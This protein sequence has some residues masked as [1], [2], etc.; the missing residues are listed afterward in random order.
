MKLK[1]PEADYAV[2]RL[3]THEAGEGMLQPS[4][5][6]DGVFSWRFSAPQDDCVM[7]YFFVVGAHDNV[8]CY[9]NNDK[10][11]GGE[12]RVYYQ[13]ETPESFQI[14]VYHPF[15]LPEWYKEGIIY[16]IFPDRF[17]RSKAAEKMIADAK[18]AAEKAAE[19]AKENG[20]AA[21]EPV[22]TSDFAPGAFYDPQSGHV[23]ENWDT[24]PYY[25]KNEDG[26]I[27]NWNFWGG[28]LAGIEEK[29]EYIRSLGAS[30]IYLNPIFEA[31]SNH[32]YDTSDYFK[33]DPLLGTEEDFRRLCSKA[34]KLGI[35]IMLDGVFN[36]TGVNSKYYREHPEWFQK[37]ENGE[38][39]CWWGVKDLPQV[40]ELNPEFS[41]MICGENGVLRYWLRAGAS[42]W[43]LDVADELP[44]EFLM[45]IRK[46]VKA[47]GQDKVVIGEV[48]EDAS[49]KFDYGERMRFFG[50]LELDS[51][52][53]YPVRQDI[54]DYVGGSIGAAEFAARQISRMENYPPEAFMGCFNMLG[55]HDRERIL[56]MLGGSSEGTGPADQ[57]PVQAVKFASA[58]L[59]S[60][61]GVPV[62]YYGDEVL[63]EGARD[64]E[65]R[66]TFPWEDAAEGAAEYPAANG[67]SANDQP[68]GAAN[69]GSPAA[70]DMT[71][72]FKALGRLRNGSA[73]LKKGNFS[74]FEG[75]NG[76][77]V[78]RRSSGAETVDFCFDRA[79]LSWTISQ[80]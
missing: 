64:P 78:G 65:N 3:Y 51:V 4:Y 57:R 70:K 53:N 67:P 50:G 59:Y 43:R 76:T 30:I 55:S 18:A 14:T 23:Y 20:G 75:D 27:K 29:L 46:A 60:L 19:T 21:G 40:D 11:L 24:A 15:T 33:I 58:L 10:K 48:W 79:N 36:H 8:Y 77:L 34:A 56:T 74:A 39:V 9:G 1:A 45:K 31:R 26:S 44:N 6:K 63:L 62:L 52:M 7:W 16:Q 28:D 35:K 73:A 38:T 5:Q 68:S 41:E 12:G 42:A 22:D 25:I 61:P 32:R 47:E 71:E 2:L 49:Y 37:D 69:A 13:G 72:H 80:E 66:G 54:L 17:R